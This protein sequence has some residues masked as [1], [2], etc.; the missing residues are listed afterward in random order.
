MV[1][2]EFT[3]TAAVVGRQ[4][5]ANQVGLATTAQNAAAGSFAAMRDASIDPGNRVRMRDRG[6]SVIA[7]N[8]Q[9]QPLYARMQDDV[10]RNGFRL[11][12]GTLASGEYTEAGMR[13]SLSKTSGEIVGFD[14]G[15]AAFTG[16]PSAFTQSTAP[17][18]SGDGGGVPRVAIIGGAALVVGVAAFFVLRKR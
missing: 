1:I 17:A 14:A 3:S 12:V 11:A 8:P 2:G 16:R 15:V 4:K 10:Q 18:S 7:A 5:I 9:L 6:A 13:N